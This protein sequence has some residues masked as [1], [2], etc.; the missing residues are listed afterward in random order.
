MAY[1]VTVW[2]HVAHFDLHG[3]FAGHDPHRATAGENDR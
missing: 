1:S 2:Y 3:A